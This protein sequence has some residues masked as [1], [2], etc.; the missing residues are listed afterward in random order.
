M[1]GW[2]L[3]IAVPIDCLRPGLLYAPR[4]PL[5]DGMSLPLD[6]SLWEPACPTGLPG[7]PYSDSLLSPPPQSQIPAIPHLCHSA[8]QFPSWSSVWR[9]MAAVWAQTAPLVLQTEIPDNEPWLPKVIRPGIPMRRN[10]GKCLV[11]DKI[12]QVREHTLKLIGWKKCEV[13]FLIGFLLEVESWL[14]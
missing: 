13:L 14:K 10:V 11:S 5:P 12:L 2:Y 3:S 6:H 1:T 7:R 9:D 8:M 4:W